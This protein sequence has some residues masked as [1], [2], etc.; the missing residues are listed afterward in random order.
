MAR[1]DRLPAGVITK[2]ADALDRDLGIQA[3][4]GDWR[5][6]GTSDCR[7]PQRLDIDPWRI[8]YLNELPGTTMMRR[9][10]L[11]AVGG[12]D[13]NAGPCRQ[14]GMDSYT[15]WDL[16]MKA[17]EEGWSGTHVADITLL[18]REHSRPRMYV[19]SL[20]RHAEMRESLRSR[21]PRLFRA[22]RRNWRRSRSSWPVKILF[23]A[24]EAIPRLHELHKEKLW[25]LV[26]GI[27]EPRLSS[28]CMPTGAR[29]I[30]LYIRKL[31]TFLKPSRRA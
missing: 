19:E 2:L 3:A 31:P 5:T 18:Y 9:D 16:W 26:R 8:T 15:D 30:L 11:L 20:N 29:L 25:V 27:F 22:R 10:A 12:W 1:R 17:A 4:W 13:M 14:P 28:D 7:V 24:I 6:F 23:P 21:N